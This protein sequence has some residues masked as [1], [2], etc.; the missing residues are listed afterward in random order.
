MAEEIKKLTGAGIPWHFFDAV[1]PIITAESVDMSKAYYGAR[2]GRR[3]HP[4]TS[5][6]PWTRGEYKN[7]IKRTCRSGYRCFQII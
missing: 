1:A 6:A 5:T 3:A 7:F 2:C 4:T